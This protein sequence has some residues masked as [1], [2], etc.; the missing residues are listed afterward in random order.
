MTVLQHILVVAVKSILPG[1]A[2]GVSVGPG[3]IFINSV[4]GFISKNFIKTSRKFHNSHVLF[5]E[6]KLFLF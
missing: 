4:I 1:D 3:D 2:G 6:I 5:R